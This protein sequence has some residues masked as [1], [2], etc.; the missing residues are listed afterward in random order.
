MSAPAETAPAVPAMPSLDPPGSADSAICVVSYNAREHLRACLESARKQGASQVV[1]V[2]NA[3][4]DGSLEMLR[5]EFPWVRVIENDSNRGYGVAANQAIDATDSPTVLLLNCDTILSPGALRRLDDYRQR[6]PE[7]AV[8]GPRLRNLDD[9]I[10]PSCYPAPTPAHLMLEASMLGKV[11][12]RVPVLRRLSVR[13]WAHDRPRRVDWLL[14]AALLID[15]TAFEAAGR[16]DKSF[17]LYYEEVDLCARLRDLGWEIHFAPLA[18]VVHVGGG[19][20]VAARDAVMLHWVEG[21]RRYYRKHY[22]Q[23]RHVQLEAFMRALALARL[24]RDALLWTRS[25]P[26]KRDD[27]RRM[28]AVWRAVL[29]G[30]DSVP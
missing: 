13:W 3:S 4:S 20:S 14:G 19:S 6:H 2:E 9:S 27:L 23:V 21:T 8:I 7:A 25:S 12:P 17:P 22:G 18:D 30:R 28:M 11:M 29:R 16:F 26:A 15:K 24:T 1:V 10:Q 5:A